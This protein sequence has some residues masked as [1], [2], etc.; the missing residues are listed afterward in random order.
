MR[1]LLAVAH[2]HLRNALSFTLLIPPEEPGIRRFC[3]LAVGLAVLTLRK[4]QHTPG[5]T[6]G[7]Q[8]KVSRRAVAMTLLA[9]KFAQ[10]NDWLLRRLFDVAAAGLPRATLPAACLPERL[11]PTHAQ[12]AENYGSDVSQVQQLDVRRYEG[13]PGH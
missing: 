12:P 6:S 8:V 1:E 13:S 2:A 9:S 4:I 11:T 7:A 3:L 10:R 5:F